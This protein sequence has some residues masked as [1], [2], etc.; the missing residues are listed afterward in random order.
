M[1][2]VQLQLSR[3][4][5]FFTRIDNIF[6]LDRRLVTRLYFHGVLKFSQVLRSLATRQSSRIYHF[7]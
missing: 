7:Y 3:F 4:C 2:K 6:I 1:G 5:Q